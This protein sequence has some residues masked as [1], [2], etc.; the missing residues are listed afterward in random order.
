M[1][2]KAENEGK[3]NNPNIVRKQE[4]LKASDDL[5]NEINA[6]KKKKSAETAKPASFI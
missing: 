6:E 4:F 2:K 5:L 3:I 1:D